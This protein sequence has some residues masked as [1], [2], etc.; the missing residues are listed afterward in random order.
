MTER[1]EMED[2]HAAKNTNREIWRRQNGDPSDPDNFYSP[3]IF[4]TKDGDIGIT[5]KSLSIILSV[6][7]WHKLGN[8][9]ACDSC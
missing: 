3:R 9:V 2:Q 7:Q 1:E 4:V 8:E 5:V 6:E